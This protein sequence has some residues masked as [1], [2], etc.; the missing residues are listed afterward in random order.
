MY[1]IVASG[2][3]SMQQRIWLRESIVCCVTFDSSAARVTSGSRG[4]D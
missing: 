4:V 3:I 2:C 1:Y